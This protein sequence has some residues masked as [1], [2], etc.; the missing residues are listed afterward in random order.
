[1]AMNKTERAALELAQTELGIAYALR[2][3]DLTTIKPD[4]PP[5]KSGGSLGALTKGWLY[6]D[7]S[8][9]VMPAC[10]S[11]LHHAIGNVGDKRP[12][13]KT[14]SQGPR[15]LYSTEVLALKALRQAL[16]RKYAESLASV[17]RRIAASLRPMDKP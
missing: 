14:T 12:P 8:G 10:S 11:S 9:F 6:N 3:S 15:A 2:W 16:E 1:M 13:P 17:D 7:Y 4:V 5:P